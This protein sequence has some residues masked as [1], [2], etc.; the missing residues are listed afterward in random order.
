MNVVQERLGHS[1]LAITADTHPASCFLT[2]PATA[3]I[4]RE[5]PRQT[6]IIVDDDPRFP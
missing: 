2:L 4:Q 1:T 6:I 3:M 5:G